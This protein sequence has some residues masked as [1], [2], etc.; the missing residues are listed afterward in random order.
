MK[1]M[2][3]NFILRPILAENNSVEFAFATAFEYQKWRNFYD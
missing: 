1:Q 2:P 3:N